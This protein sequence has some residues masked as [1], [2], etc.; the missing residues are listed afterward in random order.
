MAWGTTDRGWLFCR[1]WG[2]EL[3]D[4][5]FVVVQRLDREG[6]LGHRVSRPAFPE[7][8]RGEPAARE[9]WWPDAARALTSDTRAPGVI[10][11]AT[12]ETT[13]ARVQASPID[14]RRTHTPHHARAF[15]SAERVTTRVLFQFLRLFGSH[16]VERVLEVYS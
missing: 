6:A 8:S 12:S 3:E 15:T 2:F 16:R 11:S 10:P 13:I 5:A 1:P 9:A 7:T 4:T 14:R